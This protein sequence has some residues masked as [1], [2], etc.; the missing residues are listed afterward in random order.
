MA[1][2]KLTNAL[3]LRRFDRAMLWVEN[4]TARVKHFSRSTTLP[5]I[6]L[7]LKEVQHEDLSSW[8]PDIIFVVRDEIDTHLQADG[9]TNVFANIR[10]GM[11]ASDSRGD[12]LKVVLLVRVD[13][14]DDGRIVRGNP[15]H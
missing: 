2:Q 4:S 10:F 5:I 7:E 6:S 13:R 15:V 1:S 8:A 9:D 11:A 3:R 12:V 14:T